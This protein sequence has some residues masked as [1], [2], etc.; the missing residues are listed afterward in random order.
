[1]SGVDLLLFHLLFIGVVAGLTVIVGT[2]LIYCRSTVHLDA[3]HSDAMHVD[4]AGTSLSGFP[5][6][7][8]DQT[9]SRPNPLSTNSPQAMS[10]LLQSAIE[11]FD[12]GD[13]EL[14]LRLATKH[15]GHE[16]GGAVRFSLMG[17]IW[18]ARGET[19]RGVDCLERSA[20]IHPLD[21]DARVDLAIGYG[22]LG[23]TELS[24]DLLMAVAVKPSVE[25]ELLLRIATGLESVDE[26]RLAMEACRQAG[27]RE[28]ESADVHYQMGHYAGICGHPTSVCEAL[29]RHAIHLD[30]TNLHYRIGLAS[31]LIR[32]E[33]GAE[34]LA[35]LDHVIPDRLGEVTCRCCLKRIANLFFDSDDMQRAKRCADRLAEIKVQESAAGKRLTHMAATRESVSS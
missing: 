32:T 10:H 4:P 13:F 18:I 27:I 9:H 33:R 23:R 21:D 26:P 14:A 5:L 25:A 34:A 7:V 3:M 30:G 24:R 8:T 19:A 6:D 31:L 22:A 1:M 17:R 15:T 12:S 28:P 35:I 20:L 11:A 16:P 29:I 2:F